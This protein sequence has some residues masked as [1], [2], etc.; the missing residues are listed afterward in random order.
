MGTK[1]LCLLALLA[2]AACAPSSHF[3]PVPAANLA[4]AAPDR[5]STQKLKLRVFTAGKTPGLP[6]SAAPWDLTVA[7]SGEIWFTDFCTPAIGRIST[8]GT[9]KEFRKGLPR[10]SQP[11]SIVPGPDGNLWFSDSTV[12]AIG[13][14]TPHG[15]ITEFSDSTVRRGSPAG[16]VVGSDNAIWSIEQVITPKFV[17]KPSF[18]VRITTDGRISHFPLPHLMA[19]GS[20]VAAPGGELWFLANSGNSI[21]WLV[22]RR[23]DGSLVEHQTKLHPSGEQCCTNVAPKHLVL[24]KQGELS[25]TTLYFAPDNSND[26]RNSLATF[27][28]GRVAFDALSGPPLTYPVWPSG[29]ATDGNDLW[30]GGASA[31]ADNLGALFR[32]RP[33]G[34]VESYPV[35]YDPVGVAWNAGTVWFTSYYGAPQSRYIVAATPVSSH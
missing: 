35:P 10:G 19:D 20:L 6:A 32:V 29:I 27:S 8:D 7:P 5:G 2:I 9:I 30:V 26:P 11:T 13:R 25:F 33:D 28:T 12:G 17:I 3:T 31:F 23:A 24:D 15:T 14:I 4:A 22:E 1:S 34:K 16:I 21:T 18:L